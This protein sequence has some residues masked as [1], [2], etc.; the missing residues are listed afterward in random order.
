[1]TATY[2]DAV[3][4]STDSHVT[5]PITLYADGVRSAYRERVPRIVDNDG[6]RTL[7]VEGLDPRK[8]MPAS[9]LADAV[10]GDVDPS[11]RFGDQERDG[12]R[13]EVIFPTFALQACFASDDAG[14]QAALCRAYNDWAMDVLGSEHRL[15]PV[16]LVSMLDVDAAITQ[17]QDLAADGCRALFLPA[18]VPQRPYN[19]PEYDRF[20]AAAEEIDLPLTFHSGTGYEPRV[21]RGPGGAVVNYILGAQLDGPMVLL[22]LAAGGALDRFPGLR[23]V[24][25]E[26]GAGWLGWIMTQA[27]S[28]YEDHAMFARPKLSMKPS[29]L[30]RRQCHATFMYD[31]VAINNRHITGVETLLWGNDYPHPE[32]TWPASQEIAE[33]QFDG[34]S[35]EEVRAIVGGT[36]AEVF[37][38]DLSRL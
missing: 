9:E 21:V 2:R 25:V 17:A 36:A 7:L 11:S 32:G 33:K 23:L 31:P 1:V 37:G 16:G 24:T 14:L 20:W 15:L 13:A 27:D 22:M 19:D 26:T 34:V 30:I 35:D 12:V 28:I 10:I 5:E 18:R 29:E 4:I 38:F 3:F 6:W 8:L